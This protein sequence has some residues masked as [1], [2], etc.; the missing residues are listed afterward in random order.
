MKFIDQIVL[1]IVK[2]EIIG[3]HSFEGVELCFK[4]SN[5]VYV[6]L[7]VCLLL[8]AM[9]LINSV[10]L[11]GKWSEVNQHGRVKKQADNRIFKVHYLTP[12]FT[13]AFYTVRNYCSQQNDRFILFP[14]CFTKYLIF[15]SA[16]LG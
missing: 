12:L 10:M 7:S 3:I 1:K 5:C 15:T 8:R 6:Y 2:R 13:L 11:R 16:L 9:M 14:Q 4:K